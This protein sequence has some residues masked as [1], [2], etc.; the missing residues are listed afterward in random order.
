MQEAK[1]GLINLKGVEGPVLEALV[2]AMYGDSSGIESDLVVPIFIAAD[3]YQVG[4][5]H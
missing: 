1:N 3:A 4:L 2:S 5:A